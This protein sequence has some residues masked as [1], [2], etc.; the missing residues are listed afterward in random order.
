ML[1]DKVARALSDSHVLRLD[2]FIIDRLQGPGWSGG[3]DWRRF[4]SVLRDI[5]AGKDLRY[6][7]YDWEK[8]ALAEWTDEALPPLVIVEGI[9]L[10]QT[11]LMRYFDLTI[12][13]DRPI[14]EA[15]ERGIARDRKAGADQQHLGEWTKTWIPQDV[16]YAKLFKPQSIADILYRD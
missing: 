5:R 15:A 13:I 7:R 10:L 9:R 12:W 14:E 1:A 16:E 8:D 3:Y 2:D 4:E 11:K 6:Q